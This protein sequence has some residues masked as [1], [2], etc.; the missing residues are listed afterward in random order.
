ML[1]IT[2]FLNFRIIFQ[3]FATFGREQQEELLQRQEHIQQAHDNLAEN[4]KSILAAQEAFEQ[5]QATMFVALDRLF[6]LHN[7]LLLE[8]RSIKAFFVYAISMF[9]VYMLTSTKQTYTLRIKLYMGKHII[10]SS[11]I[12]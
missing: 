2:Y 8:S 7:A 6:A 4:S 5:K 1:L 9:V 3:Q 10:N 11:S 12:L